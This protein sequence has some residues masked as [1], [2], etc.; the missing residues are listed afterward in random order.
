MRFGFIDAPEMQQPGGP[1]AKDFLCSLISDQ[2]LDLVIL[3]KMDTGQIVDRHGRIVGVPYLRT[4]RPAQGHESTSAFW[5]MLRGALA[6]SLVTR[7]IEL[8]MVL[9]GWAWVLDRYGPDDSYFDALEDARR[10]RRGIWS[11]DNNVHPWEYKKQKYSQNQQIQRRELRL[12]TFEQSGAHIAC[13]Q[14]RCDGHLVQKSGKFGVF[15]GCSNLPR[16]RYSRS[17]K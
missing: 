3:T 8:E 5:R 1:E 11:R 9:N 10:H 16:C 7:N 2:W 6:P 17:I 14:G 15:L 12:N 13:P 4:E